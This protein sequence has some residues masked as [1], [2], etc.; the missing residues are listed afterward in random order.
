[1]GVEPKDSPLLDDG[2]REITGELF[3]DPNSLR[4]R[5]LLFIEK[6]S[7][8]LNEMSVEE[9]DGDANETDVRRG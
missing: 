2:R 5:S 4:L 1:M 9:P 3:R 6:L 8:P 7:S